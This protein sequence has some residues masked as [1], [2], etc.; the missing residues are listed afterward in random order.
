MI[1]MTVDTNKDIGARVSEL[2]DAIEN[3]HV[4][5]MSD[6]RRTKNLKLTHESQNVMGTVRRIN[7]KNK[8][9]L[10]FECKSKDPTQEAITA[11]R[12]VNLLLRHLE[13]VSH[14]VIERK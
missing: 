4:W 8:S 1:H 3:T 10:E 11:G 14:I 2:Y 13:S 7:V 12:F 5:K 9:Q 6:R